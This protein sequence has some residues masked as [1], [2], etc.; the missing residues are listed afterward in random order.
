MRAITIPQTIGIIG[1][2]GQ[3]G[4]WFRKLF[5]ARGVT[6][7]VSDRGTAL[8][9]T[10]L[11]RQADA[12]LIA[13]PIGMTDHVLREIEP[14]LAPG[15]TVVDLTSVKTPF[16]PLLSKL[17]S[18]VLSLHPMFSPA[19]PSAHG[20]ACLVCPVR[21]GRHELFFRSLLEDAGVRLV[22]MSPEEHD[23]T[24]AIVQGMTHFQAIVAGHCMMELGFNPSESLAAASPVYRMRLA[25]IGRILAQS[26]RLYAEI[27]IYNPYVQEILKALERSTQVFASA[28]E[29]KDVEGFVAAFEAARAGLHGFEKVALEESNRVIAALGRS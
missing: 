12:I 10:D 15:Q 17:P 6:T 26:P 4:A 7:L 22:T 13:V 18:G 14:L 24:M 20:Q 19:L 29:R 1:G 5:E 21:E 25:M 23:R 28:I 3:F 2:H 16:V 11:A 27:Q 8:S 9:N